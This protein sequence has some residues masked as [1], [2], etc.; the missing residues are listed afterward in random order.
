[1][2]Q[3]IDVSSLIDRAGWSRYQKALVLGTALAI[4]LDGF[5][6]QLLPNALPAIMKD[7]ALPR[8]AFEGVLAVG[9]LGMMFGGAFGGMLGDRFGRRTALVWSVLTFAVFTLA[10]A[11]ASGLRT[12]ALFRFLAG[13]GLGGA[14]PNATALASEYVPQR[15][16]PSAVTLTIVCVPLGG[17]LAALFAGQVLPTFGW[18]ALFVIGGGTSILLGLVL[19]RTLAESPRYLAAHRG[20]WPE[21][22]AL[23]NRIGLSVPADHNYTEGESQAARPRATVSQLFDPAFRRDT[24]ALFGAFFFCLMAIYIGFLL[25]PA[26]LADAGFAPIVGTNANAA[27][28]LGGVAG[29]ILGG[30]IIQQLGSRVPMLG[31]SALGAAGALV[32]ATVPL[33]PANTT[34]LIAMFAITGALFNAVQVAMYALAA[35]VYPTYIRGT[36]VGTALAVGRI[37]NVLA[38]YVG[39]FALERGGATAYFVSWALAMAVVCVSLAVVRRHIPPP[40]KAGRSP[41]AP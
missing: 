6:N 17:T 35:N 31:M 10:V 32:M 23:L 33:T 2:N 14:M 27:F 25:I 11:S 30:V 20:R 28:N 7:W 41:T 29:A 4:I 19:S 38:A 8:S 16:R 9:P 3:P 26:M 40:S 18:R 34:V 36:G 39:G 12:L 15:Y 37:G 5:D 22:T 13:L 1:L 24:F 21:L